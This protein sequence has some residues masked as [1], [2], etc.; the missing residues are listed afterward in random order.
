MKKL[1]SIML[2]FVILLGSSTS[3]YL[4]NPLVGPGQVY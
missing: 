3:V 1:S 2:S 4:P